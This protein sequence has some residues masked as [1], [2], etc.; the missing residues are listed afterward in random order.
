MIHIKPGSAPLQLK[1]VQLA[2]IPGVGMVRVTW[3][4]ALCVYLVHV[5]EPSGR[6]VSEHQT[7]DKI[8]ALAMADLSLSILAEASGMPA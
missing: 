4:R 6:L 2:I 3:S 7:I 8:R 5:R 1:L